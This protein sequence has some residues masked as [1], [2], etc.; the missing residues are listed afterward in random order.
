MSEIFYD[1]KTIDYP[2]IDSD[3]HVQE[4]PDLWQK[5]APAKLKARAPKVEQTP[6]GDV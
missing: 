4:P 5:R 3:A 2:V 1:T 6:N